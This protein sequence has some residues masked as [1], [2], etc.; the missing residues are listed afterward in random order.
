[1][2]IKITEAQ[3]KKLM[4]FQPGNEIA[5]K[6]QEAISISKGKNRK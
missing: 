3:I 4:L 5:L 2:I 6:E 1:M